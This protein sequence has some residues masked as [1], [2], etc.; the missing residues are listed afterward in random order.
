MTYAYL[1]ESQD[2]P[3]CVV[4]V[5]G[6]S[7]WINKMGDAAARRCTVWCVDARTGKATKVAHETI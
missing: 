2:V 5:G 1:I 6:M 4:S 7:A 3:V